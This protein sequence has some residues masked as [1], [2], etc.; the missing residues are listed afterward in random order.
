MIRE[1]LRVDGNRARFDTNTRLIQ[2]LDA[3]GEPLG[4]PRTCTEDELTEYISFFPDASQEEI[5]ARNDIGA[6]MYAA[7]T[8]LRNAT[9][10]STV[11]AT[12]FRDANPLV[13]TALLAY[14]DYPYNHPEIDRLA[15]LV[16]S[17][18]SYA[19]SMLLSVAGANQANLATTVLNYE[20]RIAALESRLSALAA[21][22][23]AL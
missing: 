4:T 2:Y 17:Q 23:D 6:K 22:L 8:A 9:A 11:T 13:Q 20:I 21:R 7:L 15:F 1:W 5:N 16:L 18:V 12:E 19:Y 14:R 10:D 3:S